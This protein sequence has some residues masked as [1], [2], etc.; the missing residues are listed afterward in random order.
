MK[1]KKWARKSGECRAKDRG[2]VGSLALFLNDSVTL[3][4]DNKL[5][6]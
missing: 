6:L 2:H 4:V 5:A 3:A 1:V